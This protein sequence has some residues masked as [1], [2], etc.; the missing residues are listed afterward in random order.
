MY[1]LNSLSAKWSEA[2]TSIGRRDTSVLHELTQLGIGSGPSTR[3]LANYEVT[4]ASDASG[5][6]AACGMM[7]SHHAM[8]LHSCALY[9]FSC[10]W[11]GQRVG[12]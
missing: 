12:H 3:A 5:S 8:I 10:P 4:D 1:E 11:E 7:L 6:V 9:V 2:N